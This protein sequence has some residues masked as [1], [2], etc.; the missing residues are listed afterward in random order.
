MGLKDR[1]GV[2]RRK[3]RK[4]DKGNGDEGMEED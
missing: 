2:E 1:V 4:V 3:K